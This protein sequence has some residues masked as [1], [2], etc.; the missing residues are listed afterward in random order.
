MDWQ[1]L[2]DE[3]DVLM[4]CDG[5]GEVLSNLNKKISENTCDI[6]YER[7]LQDEL[8]EARLSE[9]KQRQAIVQEARRKD[10]ER[11]YKKQQRQKK[12]DQSREAFKE[13]AE[14]LIRFDIIMDWL[15]G[16]L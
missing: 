8:I 5:C 3:N 10:F 13:D 14:A 11:K 1:P 2:F 16:K 7:K 4:R 9:M 6:C 15:M 12:K